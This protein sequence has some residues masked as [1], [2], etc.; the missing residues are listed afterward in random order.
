MHTPHAPLCAHTLGLRVALR[1]G[2]VLQATLALAAYAPFTAPIKSPNNGCLGIVLR[3]GFET[4]QG[5]LMRT[6]LF[7][8]Q[9]VTANTLETF[10]FI[11]FLLCFAVA[12]SAYVLKHVRN[13]DSHTRAC[14]RTYRRRQRRYRDQQALTHTAIVS[15]HNNGSAN[16]SSP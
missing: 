11:L 1:I 7:S 16:P 3:T 9:R 2:S 15:D 5:K 6:I 10:F 8:T 13:A 4:A 14:L 12:A